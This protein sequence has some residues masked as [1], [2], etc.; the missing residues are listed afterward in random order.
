M[1]EPGPWVILSGATVA[2]GAVQGTLT[3]LLEAPALYLA[4][5]SSQ[6]KDHESIYFQSGE[7]F[8]TESPYDSNESDCDSGESKLRQ[9][10][11]KG[12]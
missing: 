2:L 1:R 12:W 3:R 7:S 10:A 5:E 4:R 6:L 11:W 8:Q 9:A